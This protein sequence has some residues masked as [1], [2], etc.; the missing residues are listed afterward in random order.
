[1]RGPGAA[2][3][4]VG[5]TEV[6]KVYGRTAV[7]FAD[8]AVRLA[9]ADAGLKLRDVDGLLINA[10]KCPGVDLSLAKRLGL[11]DLTLLCEVQSFGASAGI[12]VA[13]AAMAVRTGAATT[14]VCVFADAPLQQNAPSGDAYTSSSLGATGFRSAETAGGFT[15]VNH[16]Y[17]LAAARYMTHY[18]VTND[19]LGAVAVS[20]RKWA[21]R[22]PVAQF[23]TPM[24]REDYHRSRWVVQPLHLFDCCV[25][26]NGGAAVVVT[27]AERAASLPRP[28]V[29]VWGWGQAHPGHLMERDSMFGLVT[30]AAASGAAA[31]KMAGITPSDVD[32]REIY[33]CYT[34]TV[35]VTLEDYGFCAKGEAGELAASGALAPG[36]ALPTN[37]G[38]GQLSGFYLWGMTPL[39]EAVLQARGEAG[40]RQVPRHDTVLVS[41]N[42]GI[43][44]HHA[45]LVLS[46]HP[47]T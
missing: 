29:H 26:S 37:T 15:S 11:R 43:L 19:H 17:A 33:D 44:D 41:G 21:A 8:E 1:M 34:Y 42:G 46:P 30:G 13:Q 35:L 20:Q 27:T 3:A 10:G 24:T 28:P 32:V 5:L 12:M 23:R 7:E 36:G 38:G 9:V 47:R 22:N 14:V 4:G 31:M 2:I 6:G 25:V 45:T 39:H 16:R 40:E 18:G